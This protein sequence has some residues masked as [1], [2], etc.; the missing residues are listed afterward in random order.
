MDMDLELLVMDISMDRMDLDSHFV[1][2]CFT[3]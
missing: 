2:R 1:K 3:A